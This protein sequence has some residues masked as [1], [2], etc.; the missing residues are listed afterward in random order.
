VI[1]ML[2][3]LGLQHLLRADEDPDATDRLL[4]RLP[5]WIMPGKHRR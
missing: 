4:A 3:G 2:W 1:A 5:D